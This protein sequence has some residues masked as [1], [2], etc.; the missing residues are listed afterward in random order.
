[1][2]AISLHQPWASWIA[3]GKK[4]IETRFW[5]THYRGDLLIVSTKKPAYQNLPLGKALCVVTVVNCRPMMP[6]DEDKAK[7]GYHPA[8][9]AWELKDIRRIEPFA[10]KGSRG[11]YEVDYPKEQRAGQMALEFE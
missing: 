1:M 9:W 2:K 3:E 5:R 8:V 10:V 7:C 4:T 11:F 6:D